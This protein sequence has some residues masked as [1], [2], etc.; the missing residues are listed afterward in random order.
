MKLSEDL[1]KWKLAGMSIYAERA[2]VLESRIK[3]LE[4]G[5]ELAITKAYWMGVRHG[6]DVG[7][8]YTKHDE[9]KAVKD[10]EAIE[11]NVSDKYYE[12]H[13]MDWIKG[14]DKGA[15]Q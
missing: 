2:R 12:E 7:D 11:V 14:L 4:E 9:A 3:E 15:H 1:D 8:E 10:A 5:Q 6:V 13:I